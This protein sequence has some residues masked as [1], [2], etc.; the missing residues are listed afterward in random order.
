MEERQLGEV[1]QLL[2]FL[3]I[4]FGRGCLSNSSSAGLVS[5]SQMEHH[6]D[7]SDESSF[8]FSYHLWRRHRATV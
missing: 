6:C 5:I 7:H 4:S 8:R 1:G 2:L 3:S